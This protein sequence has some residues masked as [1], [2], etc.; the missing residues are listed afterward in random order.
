MSATDYKHYKIKKIAIIAG[1]WFSGM[2]KLRFELG[3]EG[4]PRSRNGKC[5]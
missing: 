1:L 4:Q 3:C 2:K 5:S